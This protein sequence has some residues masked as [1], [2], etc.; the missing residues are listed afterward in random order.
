MNTANAIAVGLLLSSFALLGTW[1]GTV[2]DVQPENAVKARLP[3]VVAKAGTQPC[4]YE[5]QTG[6]MG[7]QS[8]GCTFSC[9][10]GTIS[11]TVSADDGDAGVSGSGNCADGSLHCTGQ[12]SCGDASA[13]TSSGSGNC[14]GD[15]DEFWDSGLYVSCD[16]DAGGSINNLFPPVCPARTTSPRICEPTE[17]GRPMRTAALPLRACLIL[18]GR[19]NATLCASDRTPGDVLN[20]TLLIADTI[21]EKFRGRNET[22]SAHVFVHRGFVTGLVCWGLDC[23]QVLPTCAPIAPESTVTRCTV[24]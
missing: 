21:V 16:G 2:G 19:Q 23:K 12:G 24:R 1:A 10:R 15:S 5:D 7:G 20:E 8:G 17:D 18:D 6:G 11:L 3:A 14:S 4:P 22:N 13:T 9:S